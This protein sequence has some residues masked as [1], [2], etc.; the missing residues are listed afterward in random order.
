MFDAQSLSALLHGTSGLELAYAS[1]QV[2]MA[3]AMLRA[4][5]RLR[6]ILASPLAA[7]PV[8]VASGIVCALFAPSTAVGGLILGTAVSAALGYGAGKLLTRTRVSDGTHQRGTILIE[9]RPPPGIQT[10][11]D[12]GP[13][14]PTLAHC[15][16]PGADE[17]KHFKVIGT[18]GTGKSTAIRELL[19]SALSR[20]HR[21]V[22]ADPDGGYLRRF[23]DAERGDVILNPFDARSVRWD[24][25]GEIRQPYDA[26]QLARSLLPDPESG[27]RTWCGYARTLLTAVMRQAHARGVRDPGELYRL[28]VMAPVEE[29]RS[30][31][32]GTPAQ[33]FFEEHNMR[34]FESIRSVASSAVASLEHVADQQ[35]G[36]SFSV[37]DWV[38]G[39]GKGQAPGADGGV[40]FITYRADQIAALRSTVSAWMRIAIFE[41]M[42]GAERD[43]H[44][45]FVVDE[46]DALGKIDGLKDAL[47]RVRKFG[48]RCILGFQSIAQVAATYGAG[49]AHTL[50]EN[51]GN[52]LILRCS[53][54]EGGGTSRFASTLIGQREVL[55]QTSS[56]TQRP[57]ELLASVT[58]S[59]HFSIE[60][61]VMD[62]E[63]EQLPDLS[64]YLKFASEHFWRR[65][66]LAPTREI[67][68]GR[69]RVPEYVPR[70]TPPR[71]ATRTVPPVAPVHPVAPASGAASP[72]PPATAPTPSAPASPEPRRTRTRSRAPRAESRAA[73]RPDAGRASRARPSAADR[74]TGP[75]P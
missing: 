19:G 20:G 12:A 45:W 71:A 30:L 37:R 5:A 13:G 53:A 31:S 23:F 75:E 33:P 48:G 56:R 66:E 51:C 62:S 55:R 1:V 28:I 40:L 38:G 41:A 36:R 6:Q 67:P 52:T 58:R 57:N 22:I 60:P 8:T 25:F 9:G 63:I 72:Q 73:T 69:P 44:L 42:A 15:H 29:L 26:E 21:V 2:P 50:V 34:M 27:D 16:I 47:A 39:A 59:E 3:V 10:R 43:Q 65:V 14:V 74:P 49:D 7:V 70:P 18:T 32:A 61:A 35:D 64:G 68:L 46:L 11:R 54:S 4:G 17:T 24:L